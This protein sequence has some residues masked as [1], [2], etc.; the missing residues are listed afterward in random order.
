MLA[1]MSGLTFPV[2]T[3][4]T[5]SMVFSSVTRRPFLKV[6]LD[7]QALAHRGDL[8]AAAVHEHRLHADVAE[9]HDVEQR[10]VARLLDGVAADLDDHDLAV[11]SLDV[12]QRLD[13]DLR[14]LLDRQ[15]HVV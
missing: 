15:R 5:T 13:Q 8:G 14:A 3:I 9:Q 4:F 6:G 1:T 10:L 12:G 11:E 2:S 7:A